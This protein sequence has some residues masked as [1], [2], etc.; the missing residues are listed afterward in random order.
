M[1]DD[2][3][4]KEPLARLRV[5]TDDWTEQRRAFLASTF[6][7]MW[8]AALTPLLATLTPSRAQ[9][10]EVL[11]T[12]ALVDEEAGVRDAYHELAT[13]LGPAWWGEEQGPKRLL[14]LTTKLRCQ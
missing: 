7:V 14:E 12:S 8:R 13:W 1:V 3:L 9:E 4:G 5:V 2:A 11:L 6:G 10:A